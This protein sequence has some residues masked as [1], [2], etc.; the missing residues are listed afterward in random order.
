MY[1]MYVNI[2]NIV[3]IVTCAANELFWRTESGELLLVCISGPQASRMAEV[4]PVC[5]LPSV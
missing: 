3:N 1:I 2:V 5:S 4:G